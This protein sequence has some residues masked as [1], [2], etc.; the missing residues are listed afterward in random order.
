MD[1]LPS[2]QITEKPPL[3]WVGEHPLAPCAHFFL[4]PS[5]LTTFFTILPSM[6]TPLPSRKAMRERPSQFLK[7]STTSGCCG[8]KFTSAISFDLSECGSS[9]FLPP[10]SLPIFQF[11]FEMRHAERAADEADR[12]V[13][14]LDLA[15]DVEDLDL[16][17]EVV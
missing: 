15:R 17:I 12:G 4:A 8:A 1:L 16:R 14:D 11:I 3:S 5:T 6:T 7:V 9:I 2:L 13:A 10:V